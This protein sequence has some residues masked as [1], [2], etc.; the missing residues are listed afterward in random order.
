LEAEPAGFKIDVEISDMQR[1]IKVDPVAVESLVRSVLRAESIALATISVAI[2]D[3]A[4]IH[5]VN[6]R[7]LAHDWPTDVVTFPLSDPDEPVLAGELVVSAE[8]AQR[9]AAEI[10]VEPWAELALYL[11]HG[12]LHLCGYDDQTESERRVI[13]KKEEAALSALGLSNPFAKVGRIQPSADTGET[14]TCR[15]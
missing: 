9:T 6:R 5:E 13:R 3:N 8:M 7:H 10:N 4:A 2:V 14:S 11:V 12:L 15:G 1:W